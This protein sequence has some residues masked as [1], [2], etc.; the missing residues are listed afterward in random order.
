[1]MGVPIS[2]H[3]FCWIGATPRLSDVVTSVYEFIS[4]LGPG[5][6]DP[7][8]LLVRWPNFLNFEHAISPDIE[9]FEDSRC[10]KFR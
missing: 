5:F 7:S 4:K 9:N 2:L 3:Q 6:D 8:S 1:M 10:R